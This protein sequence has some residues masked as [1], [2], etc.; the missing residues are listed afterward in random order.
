M[1]TVPLVKL[2]L[3]SAHQVGSESA[4]QIRPHRKTK[5]KKNLGAQIIVNSAGFLRSVIEVMYS[6]CF[7]YL[8]SHRYNW[9]IFR[10]GTIS[11]KEILLYFF[12]L[13]TCSWSENVNLLSDGYTSVIYNGEGKMSWATMNCCGIWQ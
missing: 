4:C 7:M 8:N 5:W 2:T 1:V 3:V 6:G 10:T 9:L 13:V 12:T 11:L